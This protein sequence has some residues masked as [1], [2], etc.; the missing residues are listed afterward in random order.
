MPTKLHV[1]AGQTVMEVFQT[2]KNERRA[3]ILNEAAIKCAKTVEAARLDERERCA[4]TV[5]NMGRTGGRIRPSH[6]HIATEIR[7]GRFRIGTPRG[8]NL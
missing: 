1:K 4:R 6:K 5:E 3:E 2:A 8:H 7:A